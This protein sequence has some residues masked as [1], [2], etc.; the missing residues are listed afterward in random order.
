MQK[1]E[2]KFRDIEEIETKLRD[3]KISR[4]KVGES[5]TSLLLAWGTRV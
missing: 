3:T 1:D 2:T 4:K 5:E